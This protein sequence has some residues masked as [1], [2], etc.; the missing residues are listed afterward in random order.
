MQLEEYVLWRLRDVPG[1]RTLSS[2]RQQPGTATQAGQR[3][4]HITEALPPSPYG[5]FPSSAAD[6]NIAPS[7]L[8]QSAHLYN[9]QQPAAWSEQHTV[10]APNDT[11]QHAEGHGSKPAKALDFDHADAAF[12]RVPAMPEAEIDSLSNSHATDVL[13]GT[14]NSGPSDQNMEHY[15]HNIGGSAVADDKGMIH[16]GI[17]VA[18]DGRS[19]AHDGRS[20]THDGRS[21]PHDGRS[22]AFDI[23]D[24]WQ[25]QDAQQM[26]PPPKA[27]AG[28]SSGAAAP[29]ATEYRVA[30]ERAAAARA[31]C[32]LLRG[33]PKS[34]RDDPHF[35]DSY[36]KSSR[37][38]FIGR[39]KARIEALTATMAA[40][41][42]LPKA[43]QP[44]SALLYAFK[45][46]KGKPV[47]CAKH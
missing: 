6:S 36:Y 12:A 4:I 32:D 29:P 24:S 2:F 27:P 33:P 13:P 26:Q 7:T 20:A 38:S 23:H 16:D 42:P 5:K 41:A 22:T 35:M 30:H 46:D 8:H 14:S 21:I 47:I 17:S 43:V 34:S 25:W 1:Q 18:Y 37:L 40:D 11:P 28:S 19:G 39:W 9:H 44:T 31:A 45:A 3:P 15:Q 10:N